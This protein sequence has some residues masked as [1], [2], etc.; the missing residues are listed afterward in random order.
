M[1]LPT[2]PPI[3]QRKAN[4][5]ISNHLKFEWCLD[6]MLQNYIGGGSAL[7]VRDFKYCQR[8]LV[9]RVGKLQG[10]LGDNGAKELKRARDGRESTGA[11]RHSGCLHRGRGLTRLRAVGGK[12]H[13]CSFACC[14]KTAARLICAVSGAI[15]KRFRTGRGRPSGGNEGR[16]RRGRRHL[17]CRVAPCENMPKCCLLWLLRPHIRL[18]MRV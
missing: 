18:M 6:K 12:N 8:A 7:H 15:S 9:Q 1:P 14:E 2:T 17:F 4:G 3:M 16:R 13:T 10:E 11:R 5:S